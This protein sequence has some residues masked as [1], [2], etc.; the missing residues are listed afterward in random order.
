MANGQRRKEIVPS[1]YPFA[2]RISN[3]RREF[4]LKRQGF[5]GEL[6]FVASQLVHVMDELGVAGA[7]NHVAAS[8]H[9]LLG[10]DHDFRRKLGDLT[11]EPRVI[12]ETGDVRR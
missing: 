1:V 6:P 11:E 9:P 7:L 4:L 2:A 5:A 3:V 10:G 12:D 8:E